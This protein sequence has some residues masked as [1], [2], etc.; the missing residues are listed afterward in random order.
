MAIKQTLH[1][2]FFLLR[3]T[4][5]AISFHSREGPPFPPLRR[6]AKVRALPAVESTQNAF[7]L[8]RLL[9]AFALPFAADVTWPRPLGRRA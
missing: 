4:I 9:D 8:P 1:S 5:E 6:I 7:R 3:L 2:L